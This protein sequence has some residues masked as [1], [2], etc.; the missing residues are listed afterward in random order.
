MKRPDQVLEHLKSLSIPVIDSDDPDL[1]STSAAYIKKAGKKVKNTSKL[2]MHM[3]NMIASQMLAVL[4]NSGIRNVSIYDAFVVQYAPK[5]N[6]TRKRKCEGGVSI[7]IDHLNTPSPS[8]IMTCISTFKTPDA[9]GGVLRFPSNNTG[10]LDRQFRK[11]VCFSPLHNSLYFFPGS[12][13]EHSV[14]ALTSG[15]RFIVGVFF[16]WDIKEH[17]LVSYWT[18][19]NY[20]CKDCYGAYSNERCLTRHQCTKR[21]KILK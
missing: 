5:F 11:S 7:H 3:M 9:V 20:V 1:T 13:I 16:K 6:D 18:G 19:S 10:T 15:R 21:S 4:H 17:A 2:N 8:H 14:S 12:L